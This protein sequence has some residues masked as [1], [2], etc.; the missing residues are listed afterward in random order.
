METSKATVHVYDYGKKHG[1]NKKKH[2][3]EHLIPKVFLVCILVILLIV[4]PYSVYKYANRDKITEID[5]KIGISIGTMQ[6]VVSDRDFKKD[7]LIVTFPDT[8]GIV[9]D[10]GII[11]NDAGALYKEFE[12]GYIIMYKDGKYNFELE[13]DGYCAMRDINDK[14]YQLL[15][16]KKCT[17][18]EVD[19][20]SK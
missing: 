1:K 16:F 17:S 5:N 7:Y 9:S 4:V 18:N 20:I 14:Q 11:K 15:I 6:K 10:R 8:S 13:T 2:K 19:Y 12:S 3:K